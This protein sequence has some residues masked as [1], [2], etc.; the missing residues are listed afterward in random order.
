M[1]LTMEPIETLSKAEA[2]MLKLILEGL[3]NREIARVLGCSV[4]TATRN[5]I[6]IF[7]KLGILGIKPDL[8]GVIPKDAKP[9][10]EQNNK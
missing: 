3:T 1:I 7:D 10:D 4:R 8:T 6:K 5:R 2:D 9:K